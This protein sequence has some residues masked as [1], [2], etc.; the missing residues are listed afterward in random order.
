ME[1]AKSTRS[2]TSDS[3]VT[4][5]GI[6]VAFCPSSFAVCWP[7]CLCIS[8]TITL[9]PWLMNLAAVSFPMPLAAP[10]ITATFPSSFLDFYAI[11]TWKY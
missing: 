3:F 9:A 5:Q 7:S 4:S 6:K 1:T 2:E 8:A 11:I 10:V